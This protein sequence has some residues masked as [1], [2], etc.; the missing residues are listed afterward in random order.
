MLP[1]RVPQSMRPLDLP[2]RPAITR[3]VFPNGL[4]LLVQE[5]HSHP[6]VAFQA[7]VRTGSAT[8]GP[9]LGTGISHVL[10]HM[11]FKG[12]AR[13]P[14]G[15]VEREARSYGGTSQGFTTVD[16]TSYQLV[17]NGEHWSEAA[18]L[19]VDAL[20]FS[21]LD[22]AEFSKER[23]VVLRELKLREDDP[24]QMVWDLLFTQVYRV[25][26]YRIPIIGYEPL[27]RKITAEEVRAYHRTHYLPNNLVIAVVGEI[28]APEVIRR[29]QELTER[30][31]PG[32]VPLV[33]LPAEPL[34]LSPREQTEE[35]A[36]AALATAA[37]GFPSVSVRDSDLPALDLLAWILGGGRG[38]VLDK[39][40]KET[41]LAHA[42]SCWNYTPMDRGLFG[43]TLRMDPDRIDAALRALRVELARAGEDLFPAQEVESAKRAFLRE[44]LAGRQTVTGQASDLAGYEVLAG[45]PLFVSR[46]LEAAARLT[47]EDLQRAACAI[48]RPERATTIRLLPQ[49]TGIPETKTSQPS[50]KKE[51]PVEKIVLEN[52]LRVLLRPDRRI[53]LVTFH[54]TALGGVRYESE[55]TNG[56]SLLTARMLTRGTRAKSADEITRQIKQMGA[57]LSAFGGRNSLGLSME[58]VSSE[59]SAALQLLGEMVSEPSFPANELEIERR[60]ALAAIQAQEEDPFSWGIRR[61]TAT[62][63]TRHPYR[64]DPS[65]SRESVAALQREDLESFYRQVLD[66]AKTVLCITGDFQR[67]EVLP[68]LQKKFGRFTGAPASVPVPEEPPLVRLRERMETTPRQE[69]LILIGFPGLKLEDPRL[70]ALDLAE[71]LLSGGAGRLFAEVRERRGLAYTVGAFGL[72]GLDPG[73]FV[74]YAVTEP[75]HLT[76]VRQALF[77]ELDRLR[78]SAVPDEELKEAREGFLGGK[79]ISQ[80][81]Q[82]ALAGELASNELYGLGFDYS[83]KIEARVKTVT[84]EEIRNVVRD[85]LDPQRCVVVVGQPKEGVNERAAA[86]SVDP[87]QVETGR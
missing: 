6:L 84:P 78:G 81:S 17:V 36:G 80:Q 15:A 46:Y 66:P 21:T 32:R 64:L 35:A 56:V 10:E 11:L 87:E 4:T 2:A 50:E 51:T 29:I 9:F 77:E 40:L 12:T 62:L 18:D 22:P 60:A 37:I 25:H 57:D 5:D 47:P 20:F 19:L 86:E 44:Y 58:V 49:G 30:L 24:N 63:F 1:E 26:P 75:A 27:L 65:G 31:E 13:R 14:V 69:A 39:A 72:P 52:G 55:A 33:S 68:L 8:E 73:A 67:S 41:G 48:L 74:L 38:S 16:T 76:Q 28:S 23:E 82:R 71:E 85:L 43:V 34:P 83:E 70:P 3:T 42:V 54:W 45:D 59:C 79:R 61:L 7:V 53:P